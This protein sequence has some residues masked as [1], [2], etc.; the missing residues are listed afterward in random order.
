MCPDDLEEEE[1]QLGTLRFRGRDSRPYYYE[2]EFEDG[3]VRT[4]ITHAWLVRHAEL[5]KAAASVGAGGVLIVPAVEKPV[6]TPA[7]KSPE[8]PWN[9]ELCNKPGA[10]LGMLLALMPGEWP[11]Q[12]ADRMSRFVHGGNSEQGAQQAVGR[13]V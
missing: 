4:G 5:V 10:V 7:V 11:R 13:T 3:R 12:H 9:I 8:L 2:V 6:A 1:L